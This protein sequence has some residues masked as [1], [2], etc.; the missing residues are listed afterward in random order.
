MFL[1]N[2]YTFEA[3]SKKIMSI[4]S[5]CKTIRGNEANKMCV[6]PFRYQNQLYDQCISDD[7]S[8]P[9][10]PTEVNKRLGYI[11][12]KWGICG[13][14]CPIASKGITIETR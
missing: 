10:C 5:D 13:Q 2:F 11:N 12:G 4:F 1:R 3:I 7:H 9:W 8:A 6:F 14:G